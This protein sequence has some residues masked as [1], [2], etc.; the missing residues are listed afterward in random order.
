ME[1][2]VTGAAPWSQRACDMVVKALGPCES[3]VTFGSLFN[4]SPCLCF[5]C[6][7]REIIV[8]ILLSFEKYE[9]V[10]EWHLAS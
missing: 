7:M 3:Y 8:A 1:E 10:L 4:L 9:I 5:F 2:K 6:K